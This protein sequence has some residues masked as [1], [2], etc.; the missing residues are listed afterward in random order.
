MNQVEFVLGSDT[1]KLVNPHVRRYL[2]SLFFTH[3]ITSGKFRRGR[4]QGRGLVGPL[5]LRLAFISLELFNQLISEA[6]LTNPVTDGPGR[7]Q[8]MSASLSLRLNIS[9]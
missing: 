1:P 8:R 2:M 9:K 4:G 6:P 3:A 5:G 7:R